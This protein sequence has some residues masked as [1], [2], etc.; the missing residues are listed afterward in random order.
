M[1]SII[2]LRYKWIYTYK[3]TLS[4]NKSKLSTTSLTNFNPSKLVYK[5]TKTNK[6]KE[7]PV[8]AWDRVG[9]LPWGLKKQVLGKSDF[10]VYGPGLLGFRMCFVKCFLHLLHFFKILFFPFLFKIFLRVSPKTFW[11]E[12]F[13]G[14]NVSFFIP[15]FHMHFFSLKK[16]LRHFL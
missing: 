6:S 14:R 13:V 16:S 4:W 3:I 2:V 12:V 10:F 9:S 5:K 7:L 15:V 8:K 11:F 1:L